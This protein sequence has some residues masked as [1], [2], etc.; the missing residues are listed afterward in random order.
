MEPQ[1]KKLKKGFIEKHNILENARI[2]LKQEFVGI[3]KIIDEIINNVSSWYTLS[4]IQEK[5]VVINLWGLTGTGKTS[6]VNRLVELLKFND[7]YYRFDLGVKT[8]SMS[9]N[10][11]LSDLCENKDEAPVIIALDEF[12]HA[13]TLTGPQRQEVEDEKNRMIWELI[14]SGKVQYV[15]WKGGLWHFELVTSK[16]SKLLSGGVRI[17]DGIVTHGKKMYCEE[18]NEDIKNKLYFF[19]VDGYSE[20]IEFAGDVLGLTLKTD[21]KKIMTSLNGQETIAFLNKVLKLALRPSI[22]NFSKALIFVMG[23]IDEAYTMSGNYS[24]DIDADEFHEMSLKITIPD[25]KQALRQRF[26]DEQIARLGNIHVIYPALNRVAYTSII[27]NELQ[28][29]A[30]KLNDLLNIEFRFDNTLIGEIYKEGVYPTQGVRPL[31]TTIH[32]L[33]KSKLSLFIAE[34]LKRNLDVLAID[35]SINNGNIVCDYIGKSGVIFSKKEALTLN[36]NNLRK[37]RSDDM[38]AITAVH[39]GGHAVLSTVLLNTIPD[40]ILSVTSDANN[41]GFMFS[42]FKWDYISRKEIISRVAFLLGGLVAEE[43]IFGKENL[44]AGAES[45]IERATGL[46]YS[47]YKN[48]GFGDVP[49]M[50]ASSKGEPGTRSHDIDGIEKEIESVIAKGKELAQVTLQKEKQLLLV[51]ADYLSKNTVIKKPELELMIKEYS[52]GKKVPKFDANFYRNLLVK[53]VQTNLVV[54]ELNISHPISL[55][56]SNK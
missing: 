42:K 45:D 34:I 26:R 33:V 39:E 41:H 23:N 54:N 19:P 52:T 2:I 11:A 18:M 12:Q 51:L 24:A 47:M 6:V 37:N 13:R 9:F 31:F 48:Q 44:T 5:P 53:E 1:L 14:D 43:L 21:V 20:I 29:S 27:E 36:L 22:K 10:S 28:N 50:Y 30:Q 46:V 38:Q 15:D 49:I 16:L 25:M 3:D 17:K 4:Y 32:Q 56:K 7:T 55:N 8:G 40:A 35:L